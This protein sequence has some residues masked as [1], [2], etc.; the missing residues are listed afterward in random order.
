[1]SRRLLAVLLGV[2]LTALLAVGPAAA[3]AGA[4]PTCDTYGLGTKLPV[5]FVHGFRSS[6]DTWKASVYVRGGEV[7]GARGTF[8]T[9]T[10]DY[11][12][13]ATEWVQ[14]NP[15]ST[16]AKRLAERIQCLAQASAT[17]KGPGKVA[18]VG[19]SM[20]GLLIRCALTP[21]CS[22]GPDVAKYAGQ[23]V[24]VGTPS[25]GSFL[26]PSGPF[27]IGVE[28]YG[29]VL[30]AECAILDAASKLSGRLAAVLANTW[31]TQPLCRF[32]DSFTAG[33]AAR[34][35][36]MNSP[37][38]G[39]LPPWPGG[40]EARTIAASVDF[41]YQLIAWE[42][43]SL[44]V[45]D[46]V[47]GVD[48]ASDRAGAEP[49]G[50][51][52]T[53]D[54]GDL[55]LTS[56]MTIRGP[57]TLPTAAPSCNHVSETGDKRIAG[58]VGQAIGAWYRPLFA[59]DLQSAPVP[60][61]CNFPAGKLVNGQLPNQPVAAGRPP[62]LETR[63]E[64]SGVDNL[65]ALGDLNRDGLGD[66]AAVVNCDAGGVGW[67]D[68]IV[69]WSA[70]PNGPA[71]LG[72]YELVDAVGD[73]RNGTLKL[74]R[75]SDGSVVVDSLDAR[76]FD[77]GCC[78]TG[79]ARVTLTWDGRTVVAT[80]VERLSGPYEVSFSGID[81]VRLG[82]TARELEALGYRAGDGDYYGC[83]SYTS[84]DDD[85]VA[86]Y[87]P[88]QDAVV[89]VAAWGQY[90]HTWDGLQ[91]GSS[92]SDVRSVYSGETVEDH[93][94]GS[95][96]QGFS[97]LLVGDGSGGWISFL[98]DDGFSVSDILVSDHEHYGAREAGCE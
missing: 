63:T 87:H 58:M 13:E 20:G 62:T 7:P 45:G 81:Q 51:R 28:L 29:R 76:E 38:L 48:S 17:N 75:E 4:A 68:N 84:G 26:R 24:T 40:V 66:A 49:L 32:I 41:T 78:V 11:A 77:F 2:V 95:M 43:G 9:E 90:V 56:T 88:G 98:T 37:E 54:C 36:T 94:D 96:G 42:A 15:E 60:A 67:P 93:L 71:V 34:A 8:I 72:A 30:R 74:T 3:P 85:P 52:R 79:R 46:L 83:V 33:S 86:T 14:D 70:T 50:G 21:S 35:F 39:K 57:V 82:M 16:A 25:L 65:V 6:G 27:A 23:V 12:D 59:A 91:G 55:R 47:V 31:V 19:H 80:D 89:K 5:L 18:L 92:L 53:L 69:F 10:F 64:G 1:M 44:N 61:L 22:Q 73:A 97:G